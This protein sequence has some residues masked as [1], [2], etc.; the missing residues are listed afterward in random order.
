[1]PRAMNWQTMNWQTLCAGASRCASSRRSFKKAANL[2]RH[3]YRYTVVNGQIVLVEPRSRR[4]V[5]VV[6]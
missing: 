4:I 6:E 1:M 5:R 3:G 2:G